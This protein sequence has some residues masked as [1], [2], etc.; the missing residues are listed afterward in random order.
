[1]K[2]K[3]LVFVVIAALAVTGI[4]TV[5]SA[6]KAQA[7]EECPNGCL[8]KFGSGCYCYQ[9]YLNVKEGPSEPE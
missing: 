1:M 3:I 2:R 9:W 4:M 6:E 5:A 8:L 7:D